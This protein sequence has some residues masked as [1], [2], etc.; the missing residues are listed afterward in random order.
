AANI[1]NNGN[2]NQ[3]EGL[4]GDDTITGNG[5]TR[6]I[7]ANATAAVTVNLSTGRASSTAGGDAASIGTD[8]ITGGVNSATGSAFD[9]TLIVDDN[10]NTYTGCG[11]NDTIDGGGSG[12]IVIFSGTR[13]QYNITTLSPSNGQ[14]T[15]ADTVDG[16]DGTDT[17][18][19]VEVLQFSNTNL[20]IAS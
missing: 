20:L 5:A 16:R 14:A 2:F 6:V 11:G 10:I 15:I 12:Y 18:T 1:G 17:V 3:F 4:D 13:G 7:Y 9:D 8:T 19:N